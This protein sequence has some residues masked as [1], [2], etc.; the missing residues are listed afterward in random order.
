M[1]GM[2]LYG[3][4]QSRSRKGRASSGA[5]SLAIEA[6]FDDQDDTRRRDEEYKLV[7]HQVFKGVCFAFRLYMSSA[8]LHSH[9]ETLRDT[10]D[11]LLALFCHD[12]LQAG[13]PG[14]ADEFTPGGRKAF[15]VEAPSNVGGGCRLGD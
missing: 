7:Y 15:G 14:T 12:P 9:T 10:V 4:S 13:L 8:T 6:S 5:A 1:A 3:L 2:R 11:Q